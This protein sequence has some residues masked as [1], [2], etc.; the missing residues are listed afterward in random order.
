[1]H[2][3]CSA[4]LPL[5]LDTDPTCQTCGGTPLAHCRCTNRGQGSF[6]CKQAARQH[7]LF[8]CILASLLQG[9]PPHD[10]LLVSPPSAEGVRLRCS[11]FAAT[12][13]ID[14]HR[15]CPR[16][17]F[18][19]APGGS[20][21]VLVLM[22]TLH[23]TYT[24]LALLSSKAAVATSCSRLQLLLAATHHIQHPPP[25]HTFNTHRH[26]HAGKLAHHNSPPAF[27]THATALSAQVNHQLYS[28]RCT[29]MSRY[30]TGS[31]LPYLG[32]APGAVQSKLVKRDPKGV[33]E[34]TNMMPDLPCFGR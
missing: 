4:G 15:G 19:S 11:H 20:P 33:G 18:S 26:T 13:R 17:P 32:R 21:R 25:L 24:T 8:T 1:M 6:A 12:F 22:Q 29:A 31:T 9:V 7:L 2:A 27:V 10:H 3:W 23:N 14:P 30:T 5:L 28:Q 16:T 34:G